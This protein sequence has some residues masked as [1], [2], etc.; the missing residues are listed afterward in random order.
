MKEELETEFTR[1]TSPTASYYGDRWNWLIDS[2]L[3]SVL[4]LIRRSEEAF[5]SAF[6]LI[7]MALIHSINATQNAKLSMVLFRS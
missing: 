2:H 4:V 1:G 3:H 5:L 7:F 6:P